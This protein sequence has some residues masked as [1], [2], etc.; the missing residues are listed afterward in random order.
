MSGG[1]DRS[2]TPPARGRSVS[3]A[4]KMDAV[5]FDVD[6]DLRAQARKIFKKA[7][8][9]VDP[10]TAILNAVKFDGKVLKIFDN[11]IQMDK[12][13]EVI[14]VGAGK[15]SVGMAEGMEEILKD[16]LSKG[17]IVTKYGHSEGHKL[18]KIDVYEAS[19]PTPDENGVRGTRK[20]LELAD[21][22]GQE[23]LVLV[24][25]SGGSSA[26]LV[27]PAEGI[28]LTDMK[29]ATKQ[30]LGCG[31]AIEEK[32]GVLKHLSNVK[33]G[34][35]LEHCAPAK[36]VSLIL[37]DVVGDPL[38]AIGS[39][40]TVADPFTYADCLMVLG[41]NKIFDTFPAS[42]RDRIVRGAAGLIAEDLKGS[43]PVF[44]DA[45]AVVVAGNSTA[46]DAAIAEGKAQGFNTL[47]LSTFME[48]EATEVAKMLTAIAKEEKKFNRPVKLPACIVIGGET[49][50]TLPPKAGVG[51]RNQLMALAAAQIIGGMDGVAILCGGTDGGDGP[52]NDSAGAVVVG[53]DAPEAALNGMDIKDMISKCD[54]Y[55]FF[56]QFEH[57]KY[58]SH[59]I[60][61]LRD[62]PT[63]TNVA[64][65][66]VLLVR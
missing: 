19:H 34:R 6:E 16:R 38:D 26:L 63:G 31:C 23:S 35:L 48:G 9:A 55:N 12:F 29:T 18:K 32:N 53:S 5:N 25:I 8:E 59:N 58:K 13:K 61:H 45:L 42:C 49:T 14:V 50:V 60:M 22:A 24:C 57:L 46:V 41:R 43:E 20:V 17:A 4:A 65:V 33:G 28:S 7:C 52:N 54:S 10:K 15:A 37:S 11:E 39:G 64:D 27:A 1:R 21:A 47:A 2:R 51:G 56:N 62:G 3:D 36:V 40:P 44:N 30:L 66:S